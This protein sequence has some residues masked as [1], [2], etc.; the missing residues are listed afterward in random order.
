M[1]KCGFKC[2]AVCLTTV[3]F[4]CPKLRVQGI[5]E[6][7]A[8]KDVLYKWRMVKGNLPVPFR[9]DE[10]AEEIRKSKS[11]CGKKILGLDQKSF[12]KTG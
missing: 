1:V 2:M 8:I 9:G 12:Q 6:L 7:Q 10:A 4:C 11:K 3:L 5:K